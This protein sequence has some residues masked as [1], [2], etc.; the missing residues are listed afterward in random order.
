MLLAESYFII[1]TIYYLNG[2]RERGFP[3][4]V[5]DLISLERIESDNG[6]GFLRID[7]SDDEIKKVNKY[8]AKNRINNL[9]TPNRF[10][11]GFANNNDA[12][13]AVIDGYILEKCLGK[14]RMNETSVKNGTVYKEFAFEQRLF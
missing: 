14:D 9:I 7:M 11:G 6:E 2:K 13:D 10:L 12:A 1:P 8:L 4:K 3:V 5:F